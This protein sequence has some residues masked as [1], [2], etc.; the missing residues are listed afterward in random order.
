MATYLLINLVFLAIALVVFRVGFRRPSKRWLLTLLCL[1]ILTA[2]FDSLA[3]SFGM[4]AYNPD[5]I[6]GIKIGEAP[7]EDFF[8]PLFATIVVPVVWN[9]LEKKHD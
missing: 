4:F 7:I 2:V 3:I 6:L 9:R 5:L 1:V 8:Y